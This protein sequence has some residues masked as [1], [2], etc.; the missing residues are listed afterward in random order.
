MSD[1]LLSL[2][3]DDWVDLLGE[4]F[5]NHAHDGEEILF[6]VDESSLAEISGEDEQESRRS[7]AHAVEAV[8][9]TNWRVAAVERLVRR[10]EM[11]G[12]LTD[13]PAIPFL[14]LTV[15][16]ASRM[17]AFEGFAAHK[18]YVPLRRTLVE[19]DQEVDAPG[20]YLDH[21]R[22]LWASLEHWANVDLGG[23]RGRL[24]VRDPGVHYGRGLAVQHAL[25]KSSDLT[26]LDAF[27][28][29]I[30]LE[31][32][33]EVAP[34]ELLRALNVWTAGRPEPWA[35]RLYRIC[36]DP[37]LKEYAQ[38]L[39]A[40]QAHQWDGKPRDP[41]TGRAI[42]RLRLGLESLRRPSLEL[43]AEFD[44][45][46]PST[47]SLRLPAGQ[48]LE[49]HRVDGWYH[50]V[51]LPGID[52]ASVMRLGAELTGSG[53]RFTFRPDIV[54]AFAYDDDLGCWVSADRMSFGD[55]YHLIVSSEL[56][57]IVTGYCRSAGCEDV[58]IDETA[59]RSLPSGWRLVMNVQM[60]SRPTV[61]PPACLASLIPVGAGP[62]LRL[63]GGLP[64]GATHGVFLRGGEPSLAL[65]SLCNEERLSILRESTGQVE[66]FRI[67]ALESREI[68]LSVL[69]LEPDRY[70]ITHGD[71]SVSVTIVDG[72]ADEA[73]IGAGTVATPGRGGVL[74]RGTSAA[75]SV[76][77]NDPL[78]VPAPPPEGSVLVL[79]TATDQ[80]VRVSLPSWICDLAG[81][82]SWRVIDAWPPFE[83]VWLLQRR[84][85]GGFD[86]SLLK[87]LEPTGGEFDPGS[88]W[89]RLLRLS[90]VR[91]DESPEAQELW[92]RYQSVIG[93]SR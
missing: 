19:D 43:F 21:V 18:F 80:V 90:Q 26:H 51:P 2:T 5:F 93:G 92:H 15:L 57:E 32:G 29:R 75:V 30:G 73:G 63:V 59:S 60:D 3:Y 46:L 67:T 4:F 82:L 71:S 64:I 27:F 36:S 28:R 33:E 13:H 42:G 49:L 10:W 37:E 81:P 77:R 1:S 22:E 72:I 38:A 11:N 12:R 24:V 62:R 52:V 53:Y 50:P 14:A 61:S 69:Q 87:A 25:I 74:V 16:A 68:P 85:G 58:R 34:S 54:Y 78:I 83:P 7:L 66:W 17:G 20:S 56:V 47:V 35:E 48:S 79:G 40:R 86:A 39:L 76:P 55:R 6:A 88:S 41:R 9:G 8:I 23:R 89:G 70:K 44:E 91:D 31:P 45:S 84:A 65:S